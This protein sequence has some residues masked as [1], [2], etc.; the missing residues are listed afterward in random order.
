MVSRGSGHQ[1]GTSPCCCASHTAHAAVGPLEPPQ[2]RLPQ[3]A[4]RS[5]RRWQAVERHALAHVGRHDRVALDACAHL[6]R[7]RLLT[8]VLHPKRLFEHPLQLLV[9]WV[10][11]CRWRRPR[12]RS[13]GCLRPAAAL[14]GTSSCAG[15]RGWRT[16]CARRAARASASARRTCGG[17]RARGSQ[18][19]RP[20]GR[21]RGPPPT[22]TYQLPPAVRALGLGFACARASASPAA[23]VVEAANLLARDA[24]RND[25]DGREAANLVAHTRELH[26]VVACGHCR[27]E[28]LRVLVLAVPARAGVA[29]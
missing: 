16:P 4:A 11:L 8:S 14:T 23:G 27:R 7:H 19:A 9:D 1:D 28:E 20:A 24:G 15:C 3:R 2:L 22:T 5:R 21:R 18:H 26:R 10:S 13:G 12:L 17:R 25:L 6:R 29:G